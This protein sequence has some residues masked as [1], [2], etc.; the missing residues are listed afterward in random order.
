MSSPWAVRPHTL[1]HPD[2]FLVLLCHFLSFA[3][4]RSHWFPSLS[5][6]RA[7]HI[8]PSGPLNLMIPSVRNVLKPPSCLSNAHHLCRE[9]FP[10]HPMQK[11]SLPLSM[12]YPHNPA[13][14]FAKAN[15]ALLYLSTICPPT[16]ERQLY[17]GRDYVLHTAVFQYVEQCLLLCSCAIKIHAMNRW[18]TPGGLID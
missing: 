9:P 12:P 7:T 4:C 13:C 14:L 11:L 17:K 6:E 3:L 5:L 8:L 18:V 15:Y 10:D 16:L 1:S 2:Y